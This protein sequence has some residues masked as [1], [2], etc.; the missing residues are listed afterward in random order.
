MSS[1]VCG[2]DNT[3]LSSIP[4][5]SKFTDVRVSVEYEDETEESYSL[6]QIEEL[7][8]IH[9]M[10]SRIASTSFTPGQAPKRN[11]EKSTA[12]SSKPRQNS[13]PTPGPSR[14]SSDIVC[15]NCGHRGHKANECRF[16]KSNTSAGQNVRVK[17][18]NRTVDVSYDE[19]DAQIRSMQKDLAH[20]QK[21]S[22]DEKDKKKKGKGRESHKS[23]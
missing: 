23:G 20:R 9:E 8:K 22:Q 19:L 17:Q 7:D 13:R 21:P 4:H 18:E 11:K 5:S 3:S 16:P 2:C 15:Y 6:L 10:A 1:N 12:S 14:S